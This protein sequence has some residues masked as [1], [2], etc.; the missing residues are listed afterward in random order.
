MPRIR[1]AWFSVQGSCEL[2]LCFETETLNRNPTLNLHLVPLSHALKLL[3]DQ[4]R[5]KGIKI[6]SM[7]KIKN[8]GEQKHRSRFMK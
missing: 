3:V 2:C 4:R 7:S 8:D 5:P 1:V 6:R